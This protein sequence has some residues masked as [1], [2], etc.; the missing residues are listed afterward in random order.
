M[1]G[2]LTSS[3]P[4]FQ[5]QNSKGRDELAL[6]RGPQAWANERRPRKGQSSN[7]KAPYQSAPCGWEGGETP[8]V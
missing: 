7:K 1:E 6:I 4:P 8:P 5:D 3:I 2:S